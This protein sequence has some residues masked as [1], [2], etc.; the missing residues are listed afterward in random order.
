MRRFQLIK[1]YKSHFS[2]FYNFK[3]FER[4]LKGSNKHSF[5]EIFFGFIISLNI[6]HFT[7]LISG[8]SDL[9]NSFIKKFFII[10]SGLTIDLYLLEYFYLKFFKILIFNTI[11]L[12]NNNYNYLNL[13]YIPIYF[14]SIILICKYILRIRISIG[15]KLLHF[16]SNQG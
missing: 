12:N 13:F 7:R 2:Y 6:F 4:V 14:L 1:I 3:A 9:I 8:H 5:L 15:N 11:D 16:T 10:V